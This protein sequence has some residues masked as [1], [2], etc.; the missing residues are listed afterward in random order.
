MTAGHGSH[1][2]ISV[3]FLEKQKY[4][5][6][7]ESLRKATGDDPQVQTYFKQNAKEKRM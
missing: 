1:P 2:Y 7:G 6:A 5:Q 3:K 4:A